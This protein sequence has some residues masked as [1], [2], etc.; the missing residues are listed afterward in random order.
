MFYLFVCLFVCFIY[1][2]TYSNLPSSLDI[3]ITILFLLLV[4]INYLNIIWVT[5]TTQGVKDK[6]K[7][8]KACLPSNYNSTIQQHE[9]FAIH[10]PYDTNET[11]HM[12]SCKLYALHNYNYYSAMVI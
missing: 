2:S 3:N 4:F 5:T 7:K 6:K 10:L 12:E 11:Q 8:N 1:I 9:V